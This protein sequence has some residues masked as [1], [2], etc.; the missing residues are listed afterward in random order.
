MHHHPWTYLHIVE[1]SLLER[2]T[3]IDHTAPG[4]VAH[5]PVRVVDLPLPVVIPW[6]AF[7]VAVAAI[8][9]DHVARERRPDPGGR[10]ARAAAVAIP[11]VAAIMVLGLVVYG[12]SISFTALSM[13]GRIGTVT[14]LHGRFF[15]P[16]LPVVLLAVPSISVT[17]VD[18]A[19]TCLLGWVVP[20]GSV[21]LACWF[22]VRVAQLYY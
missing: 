10:L 5:F 6:L 3:L 1:R 17:L 15:V 21:G 2:P 16:I 11:L 8:G 20:V 7:A 22:I 13:M 12:E 4:M 18:R 14:Y 9:V 19:P